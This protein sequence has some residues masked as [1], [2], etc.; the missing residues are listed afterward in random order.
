MH[1][2]KNLLVIFFVDKKNIDFL[3]NKKI[4]SFPLI[5][6][7]DI[8]IQKSLYSGDLTEKLNMPFSILDLKKKIIFLLAKNEFKNNS[9]I[10]LND[11]VI[12]KIERKIKKII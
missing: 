10:Q 11:Y 5:L 9:L 4:N 1:K 2:K 8:S 6:V 12:D 3:I 7:S